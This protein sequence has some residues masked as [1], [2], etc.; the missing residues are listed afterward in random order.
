MVAMPVEP[1]HLFK[2]EGRVIRSGAWSPSFLDRIPFAELYTGE[3]PS[4]SFLD[5]IPFAELYTGEVPTAV[6]QGLGNI[7]SVLQSRRSI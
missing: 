6:L 3:V 1:S 7:R 2:Q 4:P 5:R